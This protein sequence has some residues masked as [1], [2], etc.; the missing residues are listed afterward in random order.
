MPEEGSISEPEAV[1]ENVEASKKSEDLRTFEEPNYYI[2][3]I[4]IF[5]LSFFVL[6]GYITNNAGHVTSFGGIIFLT[7][8]MSASITTIA[9]Y[10]LYNVNNPSAE[11]KNSS[12]IS[13][14]IYHSSRNDSGSKSSKLPSLKQGKVKVPMA[15]MTQVAIGLFISGA[16]LIVI[17]LIIDSINVTD[18]ERFQQLQTLSFNI[19]CGGFLVL[20]IT[21]IPLMI[22]HQNTKLRKQRV[23]IKQLEENGDESGELKR[24]MATIKINKENDVIRNWSILAIALGFISFIASL[25]AFFDSDDELCM[26]FCG[27]GTLLVIISGL[28]LFR[29]EKKS[30]TDWA[31]IV[32]VVFL[33]AQT[34]PILYLSITESW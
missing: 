18:Y 4:I 23:I 30:A 27:F 22:G 3:G 34:I 26:G 28:N 31:L 20:L 21:P 33:S 1:N 7:F 8:I 2:L 15:K 11:N 17:G 5:A 24:Y 6:S 29:I 13:G 12:S 32:I 25:V 9:I 16:I 19:C 14:Q 10:A